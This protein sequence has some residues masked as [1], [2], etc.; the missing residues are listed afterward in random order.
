MFFWKKSHSKAKLPKKNAFAFRPYTSLFADKV[1]SIILNKKCLVINKLYRPCLHF[2]RHVW[3]EHHQIKFGWRL[4]V[5]LGNR[6]SPHI[7]L[8][9]PKYRLNLTVFY[10][11]GH[12]ELTLNGVGISSLISFRYRCY[13]LHPSSDS[14]FPIQTQM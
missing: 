12:Q 10:S 14:V 3:G 7:H 9:T 11:K 13:Y 5:L 8:K 4:W 2:F 1:S 6:L